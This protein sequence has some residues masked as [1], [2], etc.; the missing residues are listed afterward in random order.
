MSV[1]ATVTPNIAAL[2]LETKELFLLGEV[3]AHPY[4]A[5]LAAV[6]GM[7]K[8]TVTVYVKRLA[9]AGFLRREIDAADL[10]RGGP[11]LIQ[12]VRSARAFVARRILQHADALYGHQRATCD[13]LVKDRDQ[14]IDVRLI[15]NDLDHD[16]Q[17]CGQLDQAGRMNDAVRAK[18]CDAM[19]D[20]RTGKSLSAETL[21]QRS[22]QRRAMP[23][24]GFAEKD[25]NEEVIAIEYAHR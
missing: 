10:R 14:T 1:I 6:L 20:G 9:A 11:F 21:Q 8:P 2:G 3:E 16:W 17:I 4:P 5:E 7:P 25:A 13:H 18:P 23:L 19:H 12:S 22:R 15:V 24:V